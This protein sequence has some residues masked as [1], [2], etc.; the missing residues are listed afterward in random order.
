MTTPT[1]TETRRN[2]NPVGERVE[3]ARYSLLDGT[4]R[5]LYGQ[6]V[7][8][9][10]RLTDLPARAGGRAY[11]VERELEQDGYSALNALVADY[12]AQAQLL[13]DT[14]MAGSPLDRY[15][16]HLHLQ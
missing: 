7:L 6:R 14:P 10:V 11:L 9:V 15:L 2:A 1:V 3:L 12:L 5:V 16:E 13:G 8:G 4:E